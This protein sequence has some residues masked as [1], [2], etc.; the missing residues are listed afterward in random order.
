[1]FGATWFS[2]HSFPRLCGLEEWNRL[3]FTPLASIKPITPSP[4]VHLYCLHANCLFPLSSTPL[5]IYGRCHQSV[6]LKMADLTVTHPLRDLVHN[7]KVLLDSWLL[8]E[9]QMV[10]SGRESLHK[11]VPTALI[12]GSRGLAHSH[13]LPIAWITA[14]L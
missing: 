14:M 4:L 11:C 1:M 7:L 12:P 13:L 5:T 6:K 8:L 10:A 2:S 3:V 9:E